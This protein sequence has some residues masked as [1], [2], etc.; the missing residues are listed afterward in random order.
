MTIR[1][2]LFFVFSFCPLT[3]MAQDADKGVELADHALTLLLHHQ[4]DS[5]YSMMAES[6]KAQLPREQLEG[7]MS[8][9]EQV[10]G[11]YQ[12]HGTWEHQQQNAS[13][14]Y[15]SVID[16]QNGQLSFVVGF[17][18]DWRIHTIRIMP[19]PSEQAS[20]DMPL[21]DDA[22]E[23]NDTVRTGTD[24]SLPCSIVISGRSAT[25]PMVVLVHGSGATDR[26]ETVV[27]NRPFLDLSRQLAEHGISSLRYDKRTFVYPEIV[28]SMDDETIN[29]AMSAVKLARSYTDGPVFLLGHS[30][31]AMLAP[32]IASRIKLEGII[33]MAAPAR[34]LTEILD[35]QLNYLSPTDATTDQKQ[36]VIDQMRYQS[37]HYLQPQHQ[38][39]AAQHLSV[40]MLFLQGGR[41]YQVLMKDFLLWKKAL[42]GKANVQF[43]DYPSLNHL[44]LYGEG[45]STPQEYATKG[46]IPSEVVN[47]IAQF[48]NRYLK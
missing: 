8:Q 47:D 37:P 25:P 16:F 32:I 12:R 46:I 7:G 48:I 26:N 23:V 38:V 19:L 39:E 22:V 31:G 18:A 14:L 17:D 3:M 28:S 41:D 4:T 2:L 24:I 42:A 6:V 13:E 40:P 5:L 36:A 30:L 11:V 27:A 33:M 35:E 10:A 20:D 43:V 44:F 34:D 9:I 45:K 21:V 29:D 1:K 15:T